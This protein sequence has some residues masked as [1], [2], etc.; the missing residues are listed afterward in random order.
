ML[1]EWGQPEPSSPS[2]SQSHLCDFFCTFQASMTGTFL[3]GILNMSSLS[4]E[5]T[6]GFCGHRPWP[7]GQVQ[8]LERCVV[9]HAGVLELQKHPDAA[10][11]VYRGPSPRMKADRIWYSVRT[12]GEF[13]F[14][15]RWE[16]LSKLCQFCEEWLVWVGCAVSFWALH[17]WIQW[18]WHIRIL[19]K[20]IR[21]NKNILG[22]LGMILTGRSRFVTH[23]PSKI[24]NVLEVIV[25][26][27]LIL[28]L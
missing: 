10:G 23:L 6:F 22:T 12:P 20:K 21:E 26:E 11:W 19:K 15:S 18:W 16:Q 13:V 7:L 2:P 28:F 3:S 1:A 24:R 17:M 9:N 4:K 27:S 14:S 5:G 8:T 25:S